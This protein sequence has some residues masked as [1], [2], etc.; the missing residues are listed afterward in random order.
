MDEQSIEELIADYSIEFT[1]Y[2]NVEEFISRRGFQK[3]LGAMTK[4]LKSKD[5]I[6]DKFELQKI[7]QINKFIT[8]TCQNDVYI[9][10]VNQYNDLPDSSINLIKKFPEKT[11]LILIVNSIPQQSKDKIVSNLKQNV[12]F[13]SYYYLQNKWLNNIAMPSDIKILSEE[14]INQLDFSNINIKNIPKILEGGMICAWI[15]AKVGD[16]VRVVDMN[17]TSHFT[18]YEVIRKEI[19]KL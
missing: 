1:I 16:I 11:K 7:L 12:E 6:K 15:G 8:I 4:D 17:E 14:E 5:Y 2:Q 13:I 10:L 19:T 3:E 18:Y 9:L